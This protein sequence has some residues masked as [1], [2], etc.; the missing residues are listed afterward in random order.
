MFVATVIAFA[1]S[2]RQCRRLGRDCGETIFVALCF[3]GFSLCV[4]LMLSWQDVV[5][6]KNSVLSL[7]Q[8]LL[9]PGLSP[10]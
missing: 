5:L 2:G 1:V 9:S 10:V 7:V 6:L 3:F 8:Y 4:R